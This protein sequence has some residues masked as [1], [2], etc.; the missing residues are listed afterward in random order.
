L[1]AWLALA[2]FGTAEAQ[3][4]L[5]ST[6]SAAVVVHRQPAVPIAS[7]RLSVLANDP[8]G[9]SGAGHLIQ[10]L[11]YPS[12]RERAAR[13]GG[14][15]Q[16]QRTAD[17]VVYTATGPATELEYLADLLRSTLRPE[18][19]APDAMLRVARELRE[20]RL[21][22][23][24]TAPAHARSMLRA[25]LFPADLSAAGTDRSAARFTA[26]SIPEAWNTMYR[27]ERV[28][29][30]AVGDVYLAD[31]QEAFRD[32]PQ[33]RV[34]N[35][36]L[37]RDSVVL[38]PLA[39]AEAT[40]AWVGRAYLTS[41]LEPAAVTAVARLL[42]DVIRDR[43][44]TAQVEAE[45][46]WTHHG[47]AIVLV[48]AIPGPQIDAARRAME[49]AVATLRRDLTFL[50][51]LNASTAIRREMLFYARTP[52]RMAEVIGQFVDRDG[53]PD[54]AERFFATLDTIDDEDVRV[55]LQRLEERTPALVEIPPQAL[56]PR[57]R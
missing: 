42:G 13:V 26:A 19:P 43:L 38:G 4:E 1:L 52:D 16:V 9:F 3:E 6:E 29:V 51:V 28:S 7:L 30:V 41:D 33:A 46:W 24:E 57:A 37:E 48:A 15:V 14:A 27:P 56:R 17:A 11:L 21:A 35:L 22:E 55:V 31:V 23:W 2:P 40:R 53:D 20:E 5:R 18:E 12:L 47:Q 25:Q 45:H 39:P 8:P 36:E 10:H 44:P 32:L 34:A 49:S 54:A 50:H